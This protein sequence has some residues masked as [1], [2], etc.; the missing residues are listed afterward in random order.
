MKNKKRMAAMVLAASM[1]L[2]AFAGC[3][4]TQETKQA[5]TASDTTSGETAEKSENTEASA[6]KEAK[7]PITLTIAA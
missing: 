7:E 1:A 4:S 6:T 2:T 3:G 5:D